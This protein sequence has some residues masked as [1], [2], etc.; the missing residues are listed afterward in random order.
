[1]L[2]QLARWQFTLFELW[3]KRQC[4][5][6]LVLKQQHWNAPALWCFVLRQASNLSSNVHVATALCIPE[7]KAEIWLTV[8]YPPH[9]SLIVNV[10]EWDAN[11][12]YFC[13]LILIRFSSSSNLL[14]LPHIHSVK[15]LAISSL[16]S[17]GTWSSRPCSLPRLRLLVLCL[18]LFPAIRVFL[19]SC[20]PGSS[21]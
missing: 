5:N 6:Q 20:C 13:I 1:M 9:L 3:D 4:M 18:V 12:Q 15:S 10:L 2:F 7:N 19:P 16:P 17:R 11:F 14:L 21:W 8:T